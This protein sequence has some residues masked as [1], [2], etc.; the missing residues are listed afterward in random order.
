MQAGRP[1]APLARAECCEVLLELAKMLCGVLM[2]AAVEAASGWTFSFM[3]RERERERETVTAERFVNLAICQQPARSGGG[4]GFGLAAVSL[5]LAKWIRLEAASGSLRMAAL[6]DGVVQVAVAKASVRRLNG[7]GEERWWD[8]GGGR[9]VVAEWAAGGE[10]GGGEGGGGEGG[11][12]FGR[13]WR[14]RYSGGI[15]VPV[16]NCEDARDCAH[17][18]SRRRDEVN[19]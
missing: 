16:V 8:R 13:R 12:G 2:A 15:W 1:A 3:A 17:M 4:L 10:G 6:G 5:G 18:T 7:G 14:R 19:F 9:E 11:G